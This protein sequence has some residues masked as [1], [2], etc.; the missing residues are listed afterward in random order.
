MHCFKLNKNSKTI[1][2][3]EISNVLIKMFNSK[4][5]NSKQSFSREMNFRFF[6]DDHVFS[7]RKNVIISFI[8]CLNAILKRRLLFFHVLHLSHKHVLSHKYIR[9][10]KN[11]SMM[12]NLKKNR[13]EK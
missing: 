8:L 10:E 13:N 11:C 12:L 7:N 2:K 6:F 3:N 9:R 1:I 4:K 5:L